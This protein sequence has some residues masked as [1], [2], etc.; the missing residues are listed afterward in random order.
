MQAAR[1]LLSLNRT[2]DPTTGLL[3]LGQG[4]VGSAAAVA[5]AADTHPYRRGTYV[6]TESLAGKGGAVVLIDAAPS[7]AQ[8]YSSVFP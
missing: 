7:L 2:V 6:S 4:V 8:L 3:L 5:A 1:W